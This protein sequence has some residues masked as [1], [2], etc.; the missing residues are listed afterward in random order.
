MDNISLYEKAC[1]YMYL[2]KYN[3]HGDLLRTAEQF[4]SGNWVVHTYGGKYLD[5]EY[6]PK[7]FKKIRKYFKKP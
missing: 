3:K 1:N 5:G 7:E 4:T 2:E 6:T